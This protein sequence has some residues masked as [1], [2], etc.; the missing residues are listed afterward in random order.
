MKLKYYFLSLV[1]ATSCGFV[2][3]SCDDDDDAPVVGEKTDLTFSTDVVKVKIGSE[4][5]AALPIATGN[6]DYHAFSLDPEIVDVVEDGGQY[7]LEGFKNGSAR[8]VVSDAGNN[9]K[10][11]LVSVYTTEEMTLSHTTYDFETPMGLSASSSECHVVLGNGGY[12]VESDNSKVVATVDAETGVITMTATSA[13][14]EFTANVT[15][16]DCSGLSASIA[17]TVVATFDPFTDADLDELKAMTGSSWYIKSSKFTQTR[18]AD[19][20]YYEN[21]G[22]WIDD[23]NGDGTH[24]F[25]WWEGYDTSWDYGGHHI[26]Y[27]EGTAVGVEVSGKYLF[28]YN[29]GSNNPKYELDGSVKI[30]KDDEVSKVVIWW[31]VDMEN[32]CINRGWIVKKK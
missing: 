2:F 24:T 23:A 4:N 7:Y 17:V 1:L 13:K 31:N 11:L 6:G 22:D 8:V 18:C 19:L 3:T 9:Y 5:R 16:T 20:P 27:P 14:D 15:V 12:T 28:K 30:L 10:H 26:I 25:G 29:Y 32:E 21:Y